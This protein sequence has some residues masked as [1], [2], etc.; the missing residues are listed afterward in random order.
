MSKEEVSIVLEI[1]RNSLGEDH[2]LY[3][4]CVDVFCLEFQVDEKYREYG[5]KIAA[6]NSRIYEL[7]EENRKLKDKIMF[8]EKT[9]SDKKLKTENEML[10]GCMINIFKCLIDAGI[11]K[12]YNIIF[13]K[14]GKPDA[15][16]IFHTK[17][18][19]NYEK[20]HILT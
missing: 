13:P 11:F 9:R 14:G 6:S 2:S 19:E 3:K 16:W 20:R 17:G 10:R 8:F 7:E 5:E 1:L 18:E 4:K 15:F 12:G